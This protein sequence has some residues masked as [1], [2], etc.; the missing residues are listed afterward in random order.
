VISD[1]DAPAAQEVHR[2]LRRWLIELGLDRYAGV[3]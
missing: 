1:T 2:R 3:V